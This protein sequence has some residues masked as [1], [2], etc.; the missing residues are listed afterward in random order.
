M[1]CTYKGKLHTDPG[2]INLKMNR[3]LLELSQLCLEGLGEMYVIWNQ[4]PSHQTSSV[5][6]KPAF[7]WVPPGGS[8][9]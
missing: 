3:H 4:P 5:A 8:G 9:A 7:H 2:A 1:E 6:T